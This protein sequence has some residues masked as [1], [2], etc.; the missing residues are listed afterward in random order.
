M[1]KRSDVARKTKSRHGN[2][3]NPCQKDLKG[4]P[5]ETR[6]FFISTVIRESP[7]PVSGRER[8]VSAYPIRYVVPDGEGGGGRRGGGVEDVDV[9]ASGE[10]AEVVTGV[11]VLR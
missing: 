11:P 5:G 3:L 6:G 1:E 8:Q 7:D 10:D 2:V 4:S 9:L